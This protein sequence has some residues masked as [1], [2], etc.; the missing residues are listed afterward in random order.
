M[1]NILLIT[2]VCLFAFTQTNAQDLNLSVYKTKDLNNTLSTSNRSAIES[3]IQG[4]LTEKSV[5]GKNQ[6][7]TIGLLPE[8][9]MYEPRVVSAG[10]RN[11]YAVDGEIVLT[12]Q[13]KDAAQTF[14]VYRKKLTG[15]GTTQALA[16]SNMISNLSSNADAR[17][18]TFISDLSPKVADFYN[19]NCQTLLAD[20]DRA[21]QSGQMQEGVNILLGMP[22]KTTCRT[23]AD[24]KLLA[25]YPRYRDYICNQS[26]LN[27]K[28]AAAQKNYATAAQALKYV[29]PE[30][31]CF[32][33]VNTF[34]GEMQKMADKDFTTEYDAIKEYFKALANQQNWQVILMQDY[35]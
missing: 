32:G 34:V 19:K 35:R 12:A 15:S 31:A 13:Q 7:A 11:L 21:L 14:G 2:I 17:F 25:A 10:L 27:A 33:E 3:K 9:I 5:G 18:G 4:W 8:L 28:A 22:N 30:S 29:D 1:K 16:M 24:A 6:N 20:A 23:D 26:L